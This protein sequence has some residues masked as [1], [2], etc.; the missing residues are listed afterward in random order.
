MEI[1]KGK[2]KSGFEYEIPKKRLQNFELVE[3]IAEEETDPTAVVKVVHLLLDDK[4]AALKEHVRDKDGIVAVEAI[5]NELK[6]IF[7][8]QKDLKN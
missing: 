6:D 7:E 2:T 3:A 5:G 4:V 8:S 1:L